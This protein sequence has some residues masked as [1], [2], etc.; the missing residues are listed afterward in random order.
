M[1]T[2]TK[3]GVGFSVAA[4]AGIFTAVTFSEK[5]IEKLEHETTRYK[6]KKMVNEKFG[7]NEK[8]LNMVEDLSDKELDSIGQVV[9]EI[10]G[11]R[12][13]VNDFGEKVKNSVDIF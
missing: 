8:L 11:T 12:K 9:K 3:I 1:K 5:I 10:K 2:S 13:K 7:G 4:V 6:T